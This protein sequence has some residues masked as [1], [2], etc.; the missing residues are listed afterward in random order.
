[1]LHYAESDAELQALQS[2]DSRIVVVDFFAQWCGPCKVIAPEFEKL[3]TEYSQVAFVKVDVDV[4]SESAQKY[5]I[6]AMPTFIF[7]RGKKEMKR[8]QGANLPFLRNF[9]TSVVVDQI[10]T[11]TTTA[12]VELDQE[13][14]A[15]T[16][17]Q[18]AP[19]YPHEREEREEDA[20]KPS[21][22]P[23]NSPDS[24]AVKVVSSLSPEESVFYAA[25][26]QGSPSQVRQV[27]Q[28]SAI[29]KDSLHPDFHISP[30]AYTVLN[31]DDLEILSMV[32]NYFSA[33][34]EVCD[35]DGR[36]PL[37][38]AC[39]KGKVPYVLALLDRGAVI[40]RRDG[41]GYTAL[42]H[43]IQNGM[44]HIVWLLSERG[45]NLQEV[46]GAGHSP[47]M[48]AVYR[49]RLDICLFL[50]RAQ[51]DVNVADDDGS[52][53][54]HWCVV[55]EVPTIAETLLE[56]GADSTLTDAAGQTAQEAA[57]EKGTLAVWNVLKKHHESSGGNTSFASSSSQTKKKMMQKMQ[58]EHE[59]GVAALFQSDGWLQ[60]R[61]ACL[62]LFMSFQAVSW[63]LCLI[64]NMQRTEEWMLWIL[65]VTSAMTAAVGAF[66][67]V[68]TRPGSPPSQSASSIFSPS[69]T[70]YAMS[71]VCVLCRCI[72]PGRSAHCMPDGGCV[73]RFNFYSHLFATAVG[74]Y[75]LRWYIL[76]LYATTVNVL[77]GFSLMLQMLLS[78]MSI[79]DYT[80]IGT[81]L[82]NHTEAYLYLFIMLVA[83]VMM[84]YL[85]P[86]LYTT[87]YGLLYNLTFFDMAKL[88]KGMKHPSR[89]YQYQRDSM[90]GNVME[91]LLAKD[92][93]SSENVQAIHYDRRMRMQAERK[94][95]SHARSHSHHGHS[96]S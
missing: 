69:V 30:L 91:V 49:K 95:A 10:P 41:S 47:L 1:M 46:D 59:H 62:F 28:T 6:R 36:S 29:G 74:K 17:T 3:A 83:I 73:L 32:L 37:M 82:S 31:C 85:I 27:L 44:A 67:L 96:H 92:S 68:Q 39:I 18:P 33:A 16:S 52:T 43:A 48:W 90:W 58:G 61:M 86:I 38:Y 88:S 94:Q 84:V 35:S 76:W 60:K 42:H 5:R 70:A 87:T 34:L 51:V 19:I 77:V 71:R 63:Y 80:D 40:E 53:A 64:G 4:N 79:Y 22:A 8:I 14:S 15:A 13:Q 72:R 45:S 24:P 7:F 75:N 11:K 21:A 57:H 56:Y 23:E 20:S 93:I 50:L 2:D 65:H 89:L 25:V 9:L 78:L 12:P 54:L 26:A 66:L 55:A 81:M